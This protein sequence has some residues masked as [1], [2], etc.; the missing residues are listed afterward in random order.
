[1]LRSFFG[2]NRPVV[3][4]TLLLP[5]IAA[6]VLAVVYARPGIPALA[7]PAY[8]LLFGPI[9]QWPALSVGLGVLIILAGA[10]LV[11]SIYNEHEYSDRENYLP[12]MAYFFLGISSLEWL[13]FNPVFT[14]VLFL[15]LALR[16]LLRI[17]RISNATSMLFD[18]GFFACL[19]VLFYPPVAL[20]LPFLWVGMTQLRSATF[21]EWLVPVLG[22]ATPV[23]YVVAAY[24][25][26]EVTPDFDEF[27]D[28]AGRFSFGP[29]GD[30]EGRSLFLAFS[31]VTLLPLLIGLGIFVSGMGVS[32]VHRKN[33]KRVFMWMSFFLLAAFIFTGFLQKS[34]VASVALLAPSVAVFAGLCFVSERRRILTNILFYAWIAFALMRMLYSGVF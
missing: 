23:V 19:A 11:N 5:A 9:N 22:L 6:G 32:T 33:T 20:V 31:A 30:G 13:Y 4:L 27:F 28:L 18:A 34:E 17:Y 14:S 10:V 16:R 3:L 15:L 8:D 2:S 21:R 1:M 29:D 12:A 7:G 25:W 24:W 26:F